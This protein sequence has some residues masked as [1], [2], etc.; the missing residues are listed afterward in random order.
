[1][2]GEQLAPQLVTAKEAARLLA[3]S[4]R[5]LQ[6]L[7]K[8]GA[9]PHVKIGRLVRYRPRDLATW[10]DSQVQ[11]GPAMAP[12]VAAPAAAAISRARARVNG[13]A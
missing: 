2:A 11:G 12:E 8:A 9:I 3:I 7:T 10:T 1:M 6:Y 4:E 5:K 13:V